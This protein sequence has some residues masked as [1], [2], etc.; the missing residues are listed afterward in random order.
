VRT[1]W[2]PE[3]L[4]DRLEIFNYIAKDSPCSAVMMDEAFQNAAA[5]LADFPHRGRQGL[6]PGTRELFPH[7]HYR[8]VYE[9]HGDDIWVLAV[10]STWRQW[11]TRN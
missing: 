9:V 7:D 6:I 11:P 2:A 1:I 4:Q 5:S 8:L 3:A 10:V